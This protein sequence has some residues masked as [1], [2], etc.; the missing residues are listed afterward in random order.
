MFNDL[1]DQNVSQSILPSMSGQMM[2][3]VMD[4][5]DDKKKK[6]QS[7]GKKG[8]HKGKNTAKD[9]K[10]S[11]SQN[12]LLYFGFYLGAAQEKNRTLESMM[13]LALAGQKRTLRTDVLE[14]GFE[15]LDDG[16]S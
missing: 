5:L 13:R 11:L 3:Q 12:D 6:H 8:R 9:K 15:I 7:K 2:R 1:I 10:I 4:G 16:K 14:T